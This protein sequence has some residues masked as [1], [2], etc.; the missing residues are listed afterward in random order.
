ME[1]RKYI[2]IFLNISIPLVTVWLIC[3]L[4]PKAL[5]FFMPFVI[6]WIVAMIANPLVRFLEK[7]VKM[8]RKHSSVLLIVFV[9]ALVIG[10]LYLLISFLIHETN[11]FLQALPQLYEM[12]SR[13]VADAYES[14]SEKFGILPR[15]V[16]ASFEQVMDA[17]ASFAGDFF[18]EHAA[19]AGGAV[20]RT[21]PD[22]L[23]NVIV[24]LLSSYLFLTEH[25][26]ILT[27]VKSHMPDYAVRYA[28]LLKQDIRKVV[29]GYFMAQ[30][31][32]M[33]VVAVI[34]FAGF[35]ILQVRYGF[36]WAVAIAF[37]DFL[38][39]F[40][41]GTALIPWALVKLLA[42]EYAYA[43]GLVMIYVLSQVIRQLIQPKIVGD[44]MG[45]PPLTTLFL[46]FVG[47]R[48][49]GLAGMILAVPVGMIFIN[50]YKYGAF[51]S[52]IRNVRLLLEE[53]RKLRKE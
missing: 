47:Y 41:T 17:A 13:E 11:G 5:A 45:L 43:F 10:V 25:D 51:D 49:K 37:L 30:F 48:I 4:L 2:R 27:A 8:V 19:S 23:V 46:L 52:L 33:F 22:I 28:A 44:S 39:M 16:E 29:G 40:G 36:F 12:G 42:G 9:L 38:P 24:V 35:L 18:Q 50:F 14:F 3:F 15:S 53:I 1:A 7:R 26:R 20:A 34:L 21:L 32:I 6:G 31:K